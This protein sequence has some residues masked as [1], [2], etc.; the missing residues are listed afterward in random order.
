MIKNYLAEEK[1]ISVKDGCKIGVGYNACTDVN[2]FAKDLIKLLEPKILELEEKE[3]KSIEA[4]VHPKISTLR[5]FI[6]TF[7]YQF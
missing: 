6:E 3:G 1:K 5:E 7:A 4:I 2:F